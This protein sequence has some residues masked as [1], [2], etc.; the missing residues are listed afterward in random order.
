MKISIYPFDICPV[1]GEGR[2]GEYPEIE[3][4]EQLWREYVETLDRFQELLGEIER[5]VNAQAAGGR[6]EN[7]GLIY[8]VKGA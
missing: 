8:P 6:D 5:L 3:V 1:Y 7:G 4:S 2:R